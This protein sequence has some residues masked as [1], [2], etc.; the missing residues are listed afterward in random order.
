MDRLA[1]LVFFVLRW[2]KHGRELN[3]KVRGK[4]GLGLSVPPPTRHRPGYQSL[5]PRVTQHMPS[6]SKELHP[7]TAIANKTQATEPLS[8][9]HPQHTLPVALSFPSEFSCRCTQAG[10]NGGASYKW[11]ILGNVGK[12]LSHSALG[13]AVWKTEADRSR[14]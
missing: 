6:V 11:V 8:S 13:D 9:L 10:C 7:H 1:S 4:L 2:V 3:D 12:V 5:E 14:S